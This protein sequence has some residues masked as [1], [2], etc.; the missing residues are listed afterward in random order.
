V[1]P[2]DCQRDFKMNEQDSGRQK[3][4]LLII[5]CGRSGT[6]YSA[7][8]FRALGLNIHHERDV[9]TDPECGQDGYASWFLTVDDPQ[10][11][12]GPSALGCDFQYILHQVRDPLKVIASFAQFILQKG[13]KSPAFLEKHIPDFNEGMDNSDLS[14]KEKLILQSCR[15]WYHW[16]FL[17]E[18]KASETVQI[19]KLELL[20]PRLSADLGLAYQPEFINSISKETNQRGIY[21]VDQPWVIDWKDIEKLDHQLHDQLRNLAVHYGYE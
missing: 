21:L 16:N 7:E 12:Y 13:E 6:L 3:K 2:E 18:K 15:Y 4:K 1:Y 10:P 5:G 20:L 17:A 8:V 9:V 11:P 19:E 14:L